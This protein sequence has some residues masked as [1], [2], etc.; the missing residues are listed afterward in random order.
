MPNEISEVTRRNLSDE[1]T[2]TGLSIPGRLDEVEFF[3]RL[4]DLASLP[5]YDHRFRDMGGD[6]YQHRVVNPGDWPRNWYLTDTRIN[7]LHGPDEKFLEFL[8]LIVH[9]IVRDDPAEQSSLVGI[10]NKHLAKDGWEIA[11][12]GE[13]SGQA[14]HGGRRVLSTPAAA[15]AAAKQ[16]VFDL[17]QYVGQ[18]ITRMEQAISTDPELAIGT[19]KEYV[20]TICRTIL[21]ERGVDL[22]SDDDMPALVRAAVGCLP[23]VPIGLDEENEAKKTVKVLVNNLASM[24]RSMAELRNAYGTGH[25]KDAGHK[26]LES[27]H[28]RLAVNAATAVGVFLFELHQAN[29]V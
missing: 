26:G 1:V 27:S 2:L 15:V 10:F 21:K 9:P 7:L 29:P 5:S 19:A 12:V 4:F 28:A 3:G 8:S 23:V 11:E 17:G 24:G 14:V 6:L 13:I 18:Q 22:P 16:Q 25:G 20:E